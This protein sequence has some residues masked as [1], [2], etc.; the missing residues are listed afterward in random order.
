MDR[1][2]TK[3]I[4]KSQ[5]RGMT[6]E[7]RKRINRLKKVIMWIV[8]CM[9][10]LPVLGCVI[11]GIKLHRANKALESLTE[12]ITYLEKTLRDS[13]DE[14]E[15][16]QALLR[17]GEEIRQSTGS[18]Q[19]S[20]EQAELE[21]YSEIDAEMADGIRKVYLT[22][23]DGPSIYTEE[24]LD[25]LAEYDVKATFFVT[26]KN[27]ASYGDVYR[28]IVEE[29]HTLGM[30]S[31]SH[32]Y[33]TIYASMENF[34]EDLE[35]LR[36]FLYKVTGTVSKFYRFP[37]GSSNSVSK[38]DI[39]ELIDYLTAMD[40]RYFD[41][42]IS[43]GDANGGTLESDQ[44]VNRVMDELASHRVAVVLLHDGADKHSTVEALPKLIEKI[45]A[46][47]DGTEILP[48]TEKTMA[49]QHVLRQ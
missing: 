35:K 10:I 37:G 33:G 13:V 38:T 28:R 22:F 49:I 14:T 30:H 24:L 32:E 43:G 34:Q 3:E 44:I 29:G 39:R 1:V 5:N 2:Q 8:L 36:D 40:I 18:G 46:M 16:T 23:D 48:I 20:E 42:N 7:R 27:K 47:N 45:R 9:V 25:I 6:P 19:A 12:Q 21:A 15:R 26:G 11:L 4:K 17:I 41:W 31:Y